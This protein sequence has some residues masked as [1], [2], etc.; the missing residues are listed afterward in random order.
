[1]QPTAVLWQEGP[2]LWVHAHCSPAQS[3]EHYP[4]AVATLALSGL[5]QSLQHSGR[6]P[7]TIIIPYTSHQ[8]STLCGT[9]DDWAVLK[10]SFDGHRHRQSFSKAPIAAVL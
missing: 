5:R 6:Q 4:T 8:V 3:I 7:D 1:M 9:I 2:L 10:C